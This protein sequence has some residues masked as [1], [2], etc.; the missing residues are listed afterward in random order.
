MAA[1]EYSHAMEHEG[2]DAPDDPCI[3]YPTVNELTIKKEK[4]SR[5][6]EVSAMIAEYIDYENLEMGGPDVKC[7]CLDTSE[8]ELAKV[9]A[10]NSAPSDIFQCHSEFSRL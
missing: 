6:W 1:S 3:D 10:S 5:Q 4:E 7:S 8:N 2:I 9:Y